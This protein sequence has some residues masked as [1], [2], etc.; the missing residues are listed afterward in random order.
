MRL[1]LLC[2]QVA[3]RAVVSGVSSLFSLHF[4]AFFIKLFFTAKAPI[5]CPAIDKLLQRFLV[6]IHAFC[7]AIRSISATNFRAFVPIKLKPA[8][9]INNNA[10]VFIGRACRVGIFYAQNKAASCCTSKR[11]VKDCSSGASY[12][13]LACGRWSKSYANRRG[14]LCHDEAFLFH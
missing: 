10:Y 9:R 8:H 5:H 3:T 14:V 4:L 6:G 12:V 1:H 11:P 13:K 2:A 7:L